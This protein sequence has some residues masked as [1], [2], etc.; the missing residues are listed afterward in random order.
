MARFPYTTLRIFQQGAQA[1]VQ[2]VPEGNASSV[3]TLV[4]DLAN[5]KSTV[6]PS[7]SVMR[8]TPTIECLGLLGISKLTT[9]ETAGNPG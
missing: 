2:P 6:T 4:V 8:G 5:G 7:Q 3:E 9:G 1:V